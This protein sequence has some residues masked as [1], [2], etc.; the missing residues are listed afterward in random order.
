MKKNLFILVAA[1]A[2]ASCAGNDTLKQNVASENIPFSFSAYSSKSTKADSHTNL[3]FFYKTF[4]VYGWKKV[5][6][7]WIDV[8]NNVTNEYFTADGYG[9]VVYPESGNLKVAQEWS[10][11][12]TP[13]FPS[14]YYQE[15]RFWDKFATNYQFCAYAPIAASSEV[16]A[17]NA[18]VI[19]IGT[20]GQ[21]VTVDS[22]NLMATP[23]TE[24]A[25]TGFNKDYMTATSTSKTSAVN[26]EFAHELAKF[27]VKLALDD[28]IT[29]RQA[30]IVNEVSL[31][32]LNGTSNYDSSKETATGYL[33][34]WSTPETELAYTVNGV[35]DA[36]TG[37]KMNGE[38]AGTDNFDGYFV[39]ERLMIPQTAAKAVDSTSGDA[40][41]CQITEFDEAC[42]YVKYTIGDEPFEGYYSLANLFLGSS[43]DTE[44]KFEGGNEYT[45][46]IT[47]GPKPIYFTTSVDA[48]DNHDAE[49][50]AD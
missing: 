47:V 43:T 36:T 37:Y 4:N 18:G 9:T 2:L 6:D 21:K 44:Y 49:L 46:T 23:K 32:N 33:S 16:A 40:I 3:D 42:V 31:K 38:T 45:L 34:G 1:I 41:N 8:F 35:A 12:R 22:K 27:N 28:E 26:L 13:Q 11:I 39:M 19:T 14:W 5:N 24:L 10:T 48:W 50:D 17:T 7:N 15:I 25:Y 29:T 20:E 30:V